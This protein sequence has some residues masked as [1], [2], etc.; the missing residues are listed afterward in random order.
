MR[1]STPM[2]YTQ[3]R[4]P[5]P[6]SPTVYLRRHRRRHTR[7]GIADSTPY[8]HRR[9]HIRA[10]IV[11]VNG[12][13]VSAPPTAYLYQHCHGIPVSALPT[14]CSCLRRRLH[15][16]IDIA[17]VHPRRHYQRYT[18]NPIADGIHVSASPTVYP[19]RRRRRCILTFL[20]ITRLHMTCIRIIHLGI[21][22]SCI[23]G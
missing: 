9:R 22:R 19:C 1:K 7:V 15:T 23:T 13:P 17:M 21:I 16:H 4:I 6:A 11:D 5:V 14:A 3:L 12:I 20:H 2:H 8:R 18:R 10:D